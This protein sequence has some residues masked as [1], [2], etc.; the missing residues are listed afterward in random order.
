M[1]ATWVPGGGTAGIGVGRRGLAPDMLR[2]PSVTRVGVVLGVLFG[3]AGTG[4]SAV[5]VALPA[6]ADTIAVDHSTATWVISGYA[7]AFA[8]ATAVYG[9]VADL[10]GIRAPLIAGVALMALGALGATGSSSFVPL[11]AA[12]V[13]QG[14]GA[15][16]IPVLATALISARWRDRERI[17]ALSLVAGVSATI[18]ALGP[19]IGGAL[20]ALG[21]WR[22]AV[23]VPALGVL[24]VPVL[25]RHAPGAGTGGRLDLP[26]AGFVAVAATGLVLLVQSPSAGVVVALIG[27]G[28]LAAAVPATVLWS[29]ARPD[30]FLPRVVLSN[31]AVSR[32]A[33]TASAVPASWFALLLAVPLVLAEQGWSPLTTGLVLVPAAAIGLAV[34]RLRRALPA[35]ID[36]RRVLVLAATLAAVALL[37]AALGARLSTVSLP[38]AVGLLGT[39]VVL[40]AAAFGLGQPAMG[41]VVSD[42][43]PTEARGVALGVATLLFMVGAGVGAA[44]IGGLSEAVGIHGA[45]IALTALPVAGLLAAPRQPVRPAPVPVAARPVG[46]G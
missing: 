43:V 7:V 1:T 36:D 9:R 23:A 8:V 16:A 2:Q 32:A 3:L 22:L 26:G 12:R 44:A 46:S 5:T 18:S 28:L 40:V 45:L 11:E 42:A 17:A 29:R 21:G 19:L 14:L 13:V 34:P 27:A 39:G 24:A 15:A 31:P 30:G 35:V 10:V 37:V 20:A 6:L 33:F 4:T 38:V 25:W 41:A